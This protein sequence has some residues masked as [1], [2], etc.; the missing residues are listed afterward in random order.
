MDTDPGEPWFH[1]GCYS[2]AEQKASGADTYTQ[3]GDTNYLN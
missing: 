3:L 2:C 1:W